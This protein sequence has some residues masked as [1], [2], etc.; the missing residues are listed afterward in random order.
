[1][2]YSY[3]SR[4]GTRHRN[5]PRTLQDLDLNI[6]SNLIQDVNSHSIKQTDLLPALSSLLKPSDESIAPVSPENHV[7]KKIKNEALSVKSPNGILKKRSSFSCF[8]E[9]SNFEIRTSPHCPQS[10]VRFFNEP[11]LDIVEPFVPLPVDEIDNPVDELAKVSSLLPPLQD[12][13][14]QNEPQPLPVTRIND[15]FPPSILHFTNDAK[16]PPPN[17]SNALLPSTPFIKKER[18]LSP[19]PPPPPKPV[20][21]PTVRFVEPIIPARK[22]P[23]EPV[24]CP[25]TNYETHFVEPQ[26][27]S[28]FGNKS[29]QCIKVHDKSYKIIKVLGKGG[30]STV[31]EV[32]F[33]V[34]DYRIYFSR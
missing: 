22:E 3:S 24:Q 5:T 18:L 25:V 21:K 23:Q 7:Q 33:Q 10:H 13:N 26:P 15:E 29:Y 32:I 28:Q 34:V 30:S 6:A 31:Y 17:L 20:A 2:L 9:K 12:I 27:V 4:L 14:I 16:S 19:P 1:M 8:P 11:A